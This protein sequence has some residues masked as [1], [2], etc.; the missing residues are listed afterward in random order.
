M[1]FDID[2]EKELINRILNDIDYILLNNIKKQ[3]LYQF[4]SVFFFLKIKKLSS[5]EYENDDTISIVNRDDIVIKN[6]SYF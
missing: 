2:N 4:L 5:I 3:P 1:G 6:T